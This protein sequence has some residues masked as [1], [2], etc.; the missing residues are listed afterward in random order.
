MLVRG[1]VIGALLAAVSFVACGPGEEETQPFFPD[2]YELRYVE[3]RDCR[4]S[5]DHDLN[6]IRILADP[7]GASFYQDR[8]ANFPVGAIVI[9]EEYP[10]DDRDCTGVVSQWT[11]M[12]KLAEG[13]APTALNW[14]WQKVDAERR[15]VE[16]NP[17][18]CAGCHS[19]CG[20]PPD[21]FDGTC[22]VP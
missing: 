1:S 17:Q 5:G 16:E 2:D 14:D 7:T 22:T 18:R 9:K 20:F 13:S 10:F 19:S 12:Q 3:V 6:N 11:V 8:D 4:Q 15:V 21:G